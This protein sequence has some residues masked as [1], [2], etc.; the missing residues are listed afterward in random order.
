[1]SRDVLDSLKV[2]G[3]DSARGNSQT[4]TF[5]PLNKILEINLRF[6]LGDCLKS[7]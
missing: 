3:S 4:L 1:M 6:L 5:M 2:I 7:L